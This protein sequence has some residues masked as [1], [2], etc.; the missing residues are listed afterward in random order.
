MFER[1]AKDGRIGYS[2][3]SFDRVYDYA[4]AVKADDMVVEFNYLGFR[5]IIFVKNEQF[6]IAKKWDP[7]A[8]THVYD[9][10]ESNNFDDLVRKLKEA[11]T[12]GKDITFIEESYAYYVRIHAFVNNGGQKE[13]FIFYTYNGAEVNDTTEIIAS[14][15]TADDNYTIYATDG[16]VA[17][18]SARR[19]AAIDYRK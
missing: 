19:T 7:E 12:K 18:D 11:F 16:K 15:D 4:D 8:G 5:Y 3:Y 1:P 2:M 10:N 17:L 13:E 6:C 9:C 14:V